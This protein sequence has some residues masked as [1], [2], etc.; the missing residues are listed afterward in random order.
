MCFSYI[1]SHTHTHSQSAAKCSRVWWL[2]TQYTYTYM[3]SIR[4]ENQQQKPNR[5][6]NT[7]LKKRKFARL[8]IDCIRV[9]SLACAAQENFAAKDNCMNGKLYS[10]S[11]LA[12]VREMAMRALTVESLNHILSQTH[13]K[14]SVS[15][16]TA[17]RPP[18]IPNSFIVAA[19]SQSAKMKSASWCS[20]HMEWVLAALVVIRVVVVVIVL[21]K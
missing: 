18:F 20:W 15:N 10:L 6:W 17:T 16:L 7:T 1:H 2:V 19:M 9:H 8:Q 13:K 12:F 11:S 3:Y 5:R 21:A 4:S 14:I